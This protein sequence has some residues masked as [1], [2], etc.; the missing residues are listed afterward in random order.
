MLMAPGELR[1]SHCAGGVW[2]QA[3]R[4][5]A[6]ARSCEFTSL[7]ASMKQRDHTRNGLSLEALKVNP[8]VICYHQKTTPPL[9]E[10]L[11]CLLSKNS[12]ILL[13]VLKYL[14]PV[15]LSSQDPPN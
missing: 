6:G 14:L 4:M 11:S 5:A 13:W 9:N 10:R 12:S 2:Q 3:A 1:G 15:V 8:Q 7:V